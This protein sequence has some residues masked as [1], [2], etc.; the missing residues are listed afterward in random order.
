MIGTAVEFRDFVDQIRL[1]FGLRQAFKVMMRE[2]GDMITMADQDDLEMAIEMAKDNA[3]RRREETGKMEVCFTQ[4]LLAYGLELVLTEM[5]GLGQ[6]R[7]MASC[8]RSNH[9]RQQV[10]FVAHY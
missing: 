5:I 2:D 10:R 1:K 6:S 4:P 9:G 8:S 7:V 3:K